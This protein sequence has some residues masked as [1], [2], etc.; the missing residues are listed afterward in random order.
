MAVII[1]IK[2]YFSNDQ[3]SPKILSPKGEFQ[4]NINGGVIPGVSEHELIRLIRDK[5][6]LNLL[7]NFHQC[8]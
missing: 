6:L 2:N 5:R 4:E 1:L 3:P 7:K 8:F